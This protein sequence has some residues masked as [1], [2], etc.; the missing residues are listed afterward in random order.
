MEFKR[1]G[2]GLVDGNYQVHAILLVLQH[3]V[4]CPHLGDNSKESPLV[5]LPGLY[6][7]AAEL[8]LVVLGES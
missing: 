6:L 5:I 2:H 8:P 7:F 1:L 4:I 3:E